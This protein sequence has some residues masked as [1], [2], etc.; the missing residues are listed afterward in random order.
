MLMEYFMSLPTV[1][2]RDIAPT[3]DWRRE[4]GDDILHGQVSPGITASSSA[5]SMPGKV[6][7][8]KHQIQVAMCLVA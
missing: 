8:T 5:V 3:N 1:M 4:V 6:Q 2:H 7:Q